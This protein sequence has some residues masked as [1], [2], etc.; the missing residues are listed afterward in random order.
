M[1]TVELCPV[2]LGIVIIR[3]T[4][5]LFGECHVTFEWLKCTTT[6]HLLAVGDRVHIL[7]VILFDLLESISVQ[8]QRFPWKTDNMPYIIALFL[9]NCVK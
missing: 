6:V 8:I 9:F 4:A 3:Y 5:A 2:F 1:T 7:K